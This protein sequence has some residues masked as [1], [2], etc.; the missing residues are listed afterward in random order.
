MRSFLNHLNEQ[1][2]VGEI[3]CDMD[4]VLVD[5]IGG[6]AKLYNIKDLS[7]KNFDSHIDPMKP[8]IDKEHPNLFAELPWM[9]DG[10]Q[11]WKYI[12]KYEPNILSAHTNTWQPN[13]KKDKMRWIEKNLRPLPK[14]SHILLRRHKA[15]HAV[16]NG[17]PNILID[18]WSKNINEWEAA[19]GIG[20]KHR[21]AAETIAALKKLGF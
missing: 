18:D 11:L 10:K 12:S 17:V 20:I 16:K 15:K 6:L 9:K 1:K 3:Y 19:G 14:L 2:A 5:I 7:N 4:G 13:S 8:R 21:S